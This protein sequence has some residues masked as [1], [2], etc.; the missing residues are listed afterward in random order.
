MDHPDPV[1]ISGE[2]IALLKEKVLKPLKTFEEHHGYTNDEDVRFV[3][4][5]V[6]LNALKEADKK[7]EYEIFENIPGGHSFDRMDTKHAKEVRIKIY[8]HMAKQLNPPVGINS[9]SDIMKAAYLK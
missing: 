3:E 9:I 4:V 1:E 5:E 6:L 2:Q 8:K 7:F